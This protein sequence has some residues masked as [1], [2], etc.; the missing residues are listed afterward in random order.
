[1]SADF[2]INLQSGYELELAR[3]QNGKAIQ[4][5]LKRSETVEPRPTA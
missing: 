3:Q 2:W 1:M 4:R 5:I